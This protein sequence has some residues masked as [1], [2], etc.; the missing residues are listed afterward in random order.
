MKRRHRSNRQL[1]H[2]AALVVVIAMAQL[3]AGAAPAA[4][5]TAVLSVTTTTGQSDPAAGV[6]R[7]FTVTA[8]TAEPKRLYVKHRATGGAPCAPSAYSDSGEY[9]E[10]YE[11]IGGAVNGSVNYQG[12]FTWSKPGDVLYCMWLAA[13]KETISTPIAQTVTFR[14][15]TAT[16]SGSVDPVRPRRGAL[17]TATI[18]GATETPTRLYATI[19]GA[20][21]ASCAPTAESDTG[22]PVINGTS[23]DG[24]FSAKATVTQGSAGT[25]LICLWLAPS[26]AS[27]PIAGPQP[28]IFTVDAPPPPPPTCVVP[29]V[30]L[31]APLYKVKR[32]IRAKHCSVGRVIR[33]RSRA[34]VRGG[35]IRLKPKSRSRLAEGARVTIVVSKGWPRRAHRRRH[36]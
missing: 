4:A 1:P 12:V 5:D 26:S 17:A 2:A 27:A 20:G 29:V 34:V 8:T 32:R 35:V 11:F 13:S 22:E 31:N 33:V 21:G 3:M 18:T 28:V 30:R 15:P 14:A 25:Y 7:I 36:R 6:P 9:L 23:V 16:V 24:S 19:R 10:H